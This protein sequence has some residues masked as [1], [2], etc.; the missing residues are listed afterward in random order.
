MEER[1]RALIQ[2]GW[3]PAGVERVRDWEA[4]VEWVKGFEAG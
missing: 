3:L 1:R 4:V 2:E